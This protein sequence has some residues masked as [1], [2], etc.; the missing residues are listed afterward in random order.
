MTILSSDENCQGCRR[1]RHNDR[2]YAIE[3]MFAN[4][5]KL[6]MAA[7]TKTEQDEWLNAIMKGLS[8]GVSVVNRSNIIPFICSLT[9]SVWRRKMKKIQRT[10]FHAV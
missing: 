4:D 5:V 1:S 8:Q 3:I 6:L 9:F 7:K 10:Q 2:P